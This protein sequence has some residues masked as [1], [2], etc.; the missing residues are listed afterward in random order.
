[1]RSLR[2]SGDPDPAIPDDGLLKVKDSAAAA[3]R[4]QIIRGELKPGEKVVEGKWAKH[5]GVAQTSIREALGTLTAEG[6][7]EKGN[8]RSARVTL[9][10]AEDIGQIYQ[11]RAV[12]EGAAAR[13]IAEKQ[14][15][16]GDVELVMADMRSAV[17]CRNPD[18]FYRRD[19][20]FHLLLCRKSGNR[21]LE[22]ALR[23]LIVPL[24]AFVVIRAHHPDSPES[25]AASAGVQRSISQHERML[26]AI[27][28]GDGNFAEQQVRYSISQFA[29]GTTGFLHVG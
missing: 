12:L 19:V 15:D 27:R 23:R 6:F 5:L 3:L 18:A 10:S 21:Y 14:P 1:M 20:Q 25:W 26:E 8:G 29:S 9:L 13:I 22:Q 24:F 17:D 4:D 16:L 28:S 2:L 7:I 11:L